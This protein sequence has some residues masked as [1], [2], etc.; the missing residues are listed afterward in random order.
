MRTFWSPEAVQ[1][2][3]GKKLSGRAKNGI[4][5]L[6]NSGSAALDG[7]GLQIKNGKNIMKPYW[8]ITDED[9]KKCL[10]AVK[11][12]PQDVGY[13]RGGRFTSLFYTKV[14]MPVTMSRIN[15][16]KGLGPVLQVAEG[17]TVDIPLDIHKILDDQ[18]QTRP[19]RQPGLYRY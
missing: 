4:I 18:E 14:E 13:F 8:E 11:W 10:E 3:T 9:A 6:I 19:G 5:H 16:I 1:R 2:V 15:L 12:M 7:C 17:Y